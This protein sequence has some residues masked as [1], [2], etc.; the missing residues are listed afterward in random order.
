VTYI[1][2][3]NQHGAM[4]I[5]INQPVDLKLGDLADQLKFESIDEAAMN[6]PIYRGGPV[7]TERGF[8]LHRP[9]GHWETS[10]DISS[11]IGISTSNDIITALAA[12]TGPKESLIA[13]GYAGWGK[14]Q[15]EKELVENSWL[16][17]PAEASIIFET[18]VDQRWHAAAK[19]LGIDINQ[20]SGEIG[21]A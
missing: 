21:H 8:V 20:V 4:G 17:G 5:V 10:L 13:L 11:D 3:H 6:Q 1:C 18:R 14:G 19:L 16:S 2:E 9:L 12:G 7:E 15:L